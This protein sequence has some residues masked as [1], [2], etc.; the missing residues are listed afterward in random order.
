MR[1][2]AW[3]HWMLALPLIVSLAREPGSVHKHC[4]VHNKLS[5]KKFDQFSPPTRATPSECIFQ[6][7]IDRMRYTFRLNTLTQFRVKFIYSPLLPLHTSSICV[8]VVKRV[9]DFRTRNFFFIN[10]RTIET[11]KDWRPRNEHWSHS[12]LIRERQ[13]GAISNC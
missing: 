10:Y 11:C 5:E 6:R 2:R 8:R 9:L 3:V 13:H 1:A 4:C 7:E 12:S